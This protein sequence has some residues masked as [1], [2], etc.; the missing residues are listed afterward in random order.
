MISPRIRRAGPMVATAL[1]AALLLSPAASARPSTDDLV[2][3]ANLEDRR[4]LGD[5]VL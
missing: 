5:G 1:A 4:S 3:I 2:T